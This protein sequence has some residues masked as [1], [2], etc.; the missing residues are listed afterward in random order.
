[1]KKSLDKK[2][3][4]STANLFKRT[5]PT[6]MI[7]IAT[8]DDKDTTHNNSTLSMTNSNSNSN[9]IILNQ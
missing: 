6:V 2:K 8:G 1:M 4:N 7:N 3:N 5:K 9:S